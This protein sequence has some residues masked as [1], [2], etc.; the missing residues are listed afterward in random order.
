MEVCH[1]VVTAWLEINEKW[2]TTT[3]VVD[4]LESKCVLKGGV[5]VDDSHEVD[6]GISRP[7]NGLEDGDGVD[8][9]LAGENSRQCVS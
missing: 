7:T 5:P 6:D 8:E 9:G 1:I 2:S 4:F 3:N